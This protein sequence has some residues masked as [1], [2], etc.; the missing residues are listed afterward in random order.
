[1][2]LVYLLLN[3]VQS[4][5]KTLNSVT[6][7]IYSWKKILKSNKLKQFSL[8]YFDKTLFSELKLYLCHDVSSSN[9]PFGNIH[10]VSSSA[11][12]IVSL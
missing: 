7:Q 12:D 11:N 6:E 4:L 9:C 8:R 1:M 5:S 3:S 10:A 2:D